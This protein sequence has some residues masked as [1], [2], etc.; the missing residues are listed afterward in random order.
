[1]TDDRYQ[2]GTGRTARQLA[3]LPDG[4]VYVVAHESEAR[5]CEALL[6]ESGRTSN[7]LRFI[8]L[9][10]VQNLL[11]LPRNIIVELDHDA[12]ARATPEQRAYL[13]AFQSGRAARR[14]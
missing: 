13:R 8:T 3:G 6:A 11:G 2:R 9:A 1:M 7:A 10:G 5:H 4:S 14:A 12:E